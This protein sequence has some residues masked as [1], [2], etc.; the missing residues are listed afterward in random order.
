MPRRSR[1]TASGVPSARRAP[2]WSGA[3]EITYSKRPR[4]RDG[5]EVD[6]G[7]VQPVITERRFDAAGYATQLG[8]VLDYSQLTSAEF[9]LAMVEGVDRVRF[10]ATPP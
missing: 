4:D 10:V 1:C 3:G 7:T 2:S 8:P 5:T 9:A 6:A